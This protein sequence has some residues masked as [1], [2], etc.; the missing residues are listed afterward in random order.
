MLTK[1]SDGHNKRLIYLCF[2]VYMTLKDFC[3]D[4]RTN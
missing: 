3:K 4:N 1:L 2:K